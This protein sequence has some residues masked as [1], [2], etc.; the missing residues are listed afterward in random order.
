MAIE[1]IDGREIDSS[2]KFYIVNDGD[3]FRE[4]VCEACLDDDDTVLSSNPDG[5]CDRCGVSQ[6][7]S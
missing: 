3:G 5:D 7:P 4:F 2:R 1:K 6:L